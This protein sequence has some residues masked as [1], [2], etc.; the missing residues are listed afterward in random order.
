MNLG[1]YT[2]YLEDFKPVEFDGFK[3]LKGTYKIFGLKAALTQL[4]PLLNLILNLKEFKL[5]K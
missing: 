2:V 5:N 3:Y 4:S 1:N